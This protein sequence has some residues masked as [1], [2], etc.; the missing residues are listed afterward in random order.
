MADLVVEAVGQPET[1]N[2]CADVVR[3]KGTVVLFGV[4]KRS[5]IHWEADRFFRRQSEVVFSVGTQS[6]PD[7]W[8]FR[9]ALDLVARRRVDLAP[10]ISHR[11]PFA[12]IDE[13]FRLAETKEDGAVK[14]L[15]EFQS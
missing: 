10:L 14:V 8:P 1:I 2:L 4:P 11:L 12:R 15:L 6:E 13:A 5:A 7:H 9:L 3:S